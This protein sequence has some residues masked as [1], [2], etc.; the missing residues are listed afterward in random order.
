MYERN[1]IL[2]TLRTDIR[3]NLPAVIHLN[4]SEVS[5]W[6]GCLQPTMCKPNGM[7]SGEDR[8]QLACLCPFKVFTLET[9][10]I[11]VR[12]P[13][14]LAMP[15]S[16]LH[17]HLYQLGMKQHHNSHQWQHHSHFSLFEKVQCNIANN[18]QW[19]L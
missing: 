1:L 7:P 18:C 9:K 2:H 5:M 16:R 6:D 13:L 4:H 17:M 14:V 15:L 3:C 10:A 12:G 11:V 19:L 8:C